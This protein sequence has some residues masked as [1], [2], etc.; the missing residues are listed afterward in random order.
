MKTKGATY[1]DFVRTKQPHIRNISSDTQ[2]NLVGMLALAQL[3]E[4][5]TPTESCFKQ[6]NILQYF[7]LLLKETT[8]LKKSCHKGFDLHT[9]YCFCS[10]PIFI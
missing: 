10:L 8:D 1:T 7:H 5:Q 3:Y 9:R 2:V 4:E 6:G